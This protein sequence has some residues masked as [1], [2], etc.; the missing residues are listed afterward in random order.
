ML[1]RLEDESGLLSRLTT[2]FGPFLGRDSSSP[3]RNLARRLVV[4]IA[5]LCRCAG[6]FTTF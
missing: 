6:G 2:G 5:N 1:A 4:S 3:G